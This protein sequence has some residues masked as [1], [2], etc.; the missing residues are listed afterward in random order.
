VDIEGTGK[1]VL[2]NAPLA[3]AFVKP[4]DYKGAVPV[5]FY[6]P[7][8]WKR[9]VISQ[10]LEG[11]LHGLAVTDWNKDAGEDILTASFTGVD[12]FSFGKK[13]RWERTRIV[14]GNPDPWP[15]SGSSEIAVGHLAR[16]RFL[17]TIEPWHG[18][19]VVVYRQ[20][21]QKW[22]RQVIDTTLNDG[23]VLD[24]RPES[25]QQG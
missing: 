13:K 17:S 15:R 1:R 7:G 20:Q 16:A 3:G 25:G 23:H 14:N 19:Q 21:G 24:R 5:V 2:V 9:E 18:N 10:E 22:Q 8:V 12:V 11:V 4:P 6:R